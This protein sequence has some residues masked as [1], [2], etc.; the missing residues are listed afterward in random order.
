MADALDLGSSVAIRK[1]SSPFS[2]TISVSAIFKVSI[3]GCKWS[4]I[5]NGLLNFGRFRLAIRIR[6]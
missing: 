5:T 3:F 6:T 1:G 2:R 4:W